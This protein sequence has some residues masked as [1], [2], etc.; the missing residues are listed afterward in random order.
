MLLFFRQFL[1]FVLEILYGLIEAAT[2]RT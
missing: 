1:S 2:V